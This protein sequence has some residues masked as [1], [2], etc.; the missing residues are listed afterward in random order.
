[1]SPTPR[2]RVRSEL[3]GREASG[4]APPPRTLGV[5]RSPPAA[6]ALASAA[7][8]ARAMASSRVRSWKIWSTSPLTCAIAAPTALA[9]AWC[10]T[11]S[12]SE[13]PAKRRGRRG[14]ARPVAQVDEAGG[15]RHVGHGE[16]V[17]AEHQRLLGEAV[18]HAGRPDGQRLARHAGA[19]AQPERQEIRP[20]EERAHAADLHHA[21][22][23]AREAVAQAAD[24]GGGAAH[25]DHQGLVAL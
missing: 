2:T 13:T 6:T 25:V 14:D 1:M 7:R 20:A 4:R 11:F 15:H 18:A 22:G 17:A 9:T 24:V 5:A 3:P 8:R 19:A 23:L 12:N 21:V 16:H 10:G